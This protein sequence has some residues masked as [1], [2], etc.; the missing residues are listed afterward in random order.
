[1]NKFT[2]LVLISM[3]VALFSSKTIASS[4]VSFN[5]T[6]DTAITAPLERKKTCYK[7]GGRKV[8]I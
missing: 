2:S 7:K 5:Q 8:C 3:S 1:M 6:Q 4:S